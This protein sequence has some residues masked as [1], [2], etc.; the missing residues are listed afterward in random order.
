MA[1]TNVCW[2]IE[3]GASAIKAVKLSN[4]SGSVRVLEHA[5]IAHPKVLSTPGVD[6]NDVLRVSLGA[7]T[8]QYDLSKAAIAVS[9]PGHSAFA[10]FAKLP[11]VEP[12]KVPDIVKF[13]AMQQIPF[14]L[15]QV[16]WDYQTFVSPD[17]PDV[18]VGI[19]A[20]T[21]ERVAE[22]LK[23][24]SDFGIT[25]N[26]VVLSPIAVYNALAYDLEFNN[27]TPGTIIV[28]V[29]TTSTDLVIATPGKMWVRTF[30]IG[31]HQFT[32]ALVESFQ[33]SYAKAEKV[34]R[35]AEDT[36]YARQVFQTLRPIFTDLAQDI[37]RSVGYFQSINKDVELTR[38]IGVGS[39]FRLP[40][41][42]KY[43]KQQLNLDVYRVEQFKR[44]TLEDGKLGP[45]PE[46]DDRR[47]K[48][49]DQTLELTTAYGLA[50]QGLGLNAVG[51]NLMPIPE[52]R[53]AMWK[54]KVPWFAM[55][56]G[57][58][59]VA[60][61]SMFIGPLRDW[62]TSNN[63]VPDPM[64]NTVVSAVTNLKNDAQAAGVLDAAQPDLGAA[65]RAALLE[66][67]EIFPFITS[68]VSALFAAGN[69]EAT[70]VAGET[71]AA[72]IIPAFVLHTFVTEYLPPSGDPAAAA[73]GGEPVPSGGMNSGGED[74]GPVALQGFRRIKCV[75]DFKIR[76]K[77]SSEANRF[78]RG[79]VAQWSKG[80]AVRADVPYQVSDWSFN[81]R[82]EGAGA[83]GGGGGDF[84][85]PAPGGGGRGRVLGEGSPT[86]GRGGGGEFVPRPGQGRAAGGT[87]DPN[88][89]AAISQLD[90]LAPL[91]ASTAAGSDLPAFRVT[92]TWYSVFK[93]PVD[94]NA[95]ADATNG[96]GK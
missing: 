37:Q 36:T 81:V 92:L 39:T 31:G 23:I 83:P 41:L 57:L 45:I 6:P 67:R 47:V 42:R 35:E 60:G 40:G 77:D 11:P 44:A 14:P 30:P 33:L 66:N 95:P 90:A 56:A 78:V 61:G 38:L 43:L 76:A 2:G 49:D 96:G 63:Q 28:D 16:E 75:A 13:E 7:L 24:L 12:K 50:L 72:P 79:A 68:D 3:V 1:S 54:E 85:G 86:E 20:I 25:P 73:A 88:G 17:S 46:T 89:A 91:M 10:R 94:P 74:L 82:P 26:Y 22:R 65:N 70:R 5:V 19:F 15:E 87:E 29:G 51:G 71:S 64:I 4:E 59:V 62:V 84:G 69:A 52:V 9:V 18:E 27:T 55:A 48:F 32:Q 80:V 58:A 34:K 93:P 8:S 21:K 53:K